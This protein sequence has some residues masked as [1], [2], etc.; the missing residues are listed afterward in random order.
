M[1]NSWTFIRRAVRI[2]ITA[3]ALFVMAFCGFNAL[4]AEPS[5]KS[6]IS[7][8]SILES[9]TR[10]TLNAVSEYVRANPQADDVE[11]AYRWLFV[12]AAAQ[13]LEGDVLSLSEEYV[14]RPTHAS[15]SHGLARRV[16]S[17][18]KAKSGKLPEAIALFQDDLNEANIRNAD[19][20]LDFGV[21][22]VEHLQLQG[23]FAAARQI[24]DGLASRLFLNSFVR[25]F[26]ELRM[27]H[28][29]L[30]RRKS[31]KIGTIDIDG[32]PVNLDDYAGKVVLVDFWATNCEPC[33]RQF[34]AMKKLYEEFHDKGLEI[35]GISL[36]EQRSTLAAFQQEF[37]LPWRLA[38]SGSDRDETRRRYRA[39]KVPTM[40]LVDQ[41][42]DVA[43]VDLHE[44]RIRMGVEKLL[45]V[46]K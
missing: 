19:S 12:T 36:D 20:N 43:Y 42:G 38:L 39:D 17:I 15:S 35:I 6:E 9:Q 29:E 3:L 11:E 32:K 13:G 16:A 8:A 44:Q 25:E 1:I 37:K 26:C 34:P 30:A 45:G 27:R 41:K 24:Y 5:P 28:L 4:A 10:A 14:K 23:D 7:L 21:L 33:L 46:G 18:G 31:P 2:S 40:Y 22:L